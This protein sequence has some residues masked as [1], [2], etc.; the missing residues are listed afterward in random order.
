MGTYTKGSG[1]A[2]GV[3]LDPRCSAA[4]RRTG[5]GQRSELRAAP[6]RAG[7]LRGRR[8]GTG[9]HRCAQGARQFGLSAEPRGR[10]QHGG[11]RGGD[12]RQRLFRPG[13]RQP[14]AALL[15]R[16]AGSGRAE[17]AG[18]DHGAA[19]PLDP[20]GARASRPPVAGSGGGR[21]GDQC[22]RHRRAA[23]RQSARCR[24]LRLASDTVPRRRHEPR[25]R[26]SPGSRRR[27]SRPGRARELRN[28]RGV[29]PGAARRQPVRGRRHRGQCAGGCGAVRLDHPPRDR[30]GRGRR[31]KERG[32]LRVAHR[33][34]RPHPR[35]P[36]PSAGRLAGTGG[37]LHPPR[38]RG[39]PSARIR[40][41]SSGQPDRARSSRRAR[42]GAD[43]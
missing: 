31:S 40:L 20:V 34:A 23:S 41:A 27:R 17:T 6:D 2:Q 7:P 4:R 8:E 43:P 42:F 33:P 32:G 16:R 11:H 36:L 29:P 14:G 15:A 25:D 1:G 5:V 39:L 28:P 26:A 10:H 22:A 12:V 21:A 19:P 13:S 3:S 38:R 24:R 37:H 30:V 35:L 9:A 18:A